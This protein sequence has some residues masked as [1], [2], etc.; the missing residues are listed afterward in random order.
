MADLELSLAMTRSDRIEALA[1][2]QVKPKGITL[3]YQDL[4]L[5]EIWSSQ[6]RFNKFDVSE[7]SFS[8]FLRARA[9]G[10]D[11]RMIPVFHNRG[12]TYTRILVRTGSGVR[13][14]HPED[15]RGKRIGI[16][17]YQQS[18]GV[19]T[20]GILQHEFGVRVQDVEWFQGRA[21]PFIPGQEDNFRPPPDVRLHREPADLVTM[22]L[23]G[24]LDAAFTLGSGLVRR[25]TEE[26]DDPTKFSPLF[27]DAKKEGIR[28]YRNTG[29][30]PPHHVTIVRDSLLQEHPWVAGSLGEA[31][32]ESRRIALGHLE[33]R[34]PTLLVFGKQALEEQRAI[35]GDDPYVDGLQANRAAVDMFQT[36]SLEQGL[37]SRKQPWEELFPA[38]VV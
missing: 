38:G 10:W 36:F 28:F 18:A 8:F 31:F 1:A 21:E 15:L 2:G 12:F 4:S 26:L 37:T 23:E 16:T 32:A 27:L 29:V 9:Y 30:F 33:K 22:L 6:L 11:Y 20:R 5:P 34:P 19:W 25:P 24:E 13:F 35:F 7:M 14:D 17:D 3:A